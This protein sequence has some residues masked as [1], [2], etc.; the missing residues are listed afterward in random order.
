MICVKLRKENI[1]N[2]K[3]FQELYAQSQSSQHKEYLA[4]TSSLAPLESNGYFFTHAMDSAI[5]ADMFVEEFIAQ[6]KHYP[7]L[8]AFIKANVNL[9]EIVVSYAKLHDLGK[10][11]KKLQAMFKDNNK[12]DSLDSHSFGSAV[13]C[14]NILNHKPITQFELEKLE[15]LPAF[16]DI[17]SLHHLQLVDTY[18]TRMRNYEINLGSKE[19]NHYITK[20]TVK[21]LQTYFA[22][23][24]ENM[25]GQDK[26][27]PLVVRMLV[28]NLVKMA[29]DLASNKE[30]YTEQPFNSAKVYATY[31][32]K[33]KYEYG[34]TNMAHTYNLLYQ[35]LGN[36][37]ESILYYCKRNNIKDL[38]PKRKL[39]YAFVLSEAQSLINL[40][41]QQ[42]KDKQQYL[43][44][45]SKQAGT[46][47]I[48]QKYK[49]DLEQE[50][51]Q[52]KAQLP[53]PKKK[54]FF[55]F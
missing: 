38:I 46:I 49:Q 14:N 25:R 6:C 15:T 50:N 48:L 24:I 5:F 34:Y 10:L 21:Y 55:W 13:I 39:G 31:Y 44:T 30:R 45:I 22:R 12:T 41:Y 28:L 33:H 36:R 3:L 19:P 42:E 29:D 11:E 40:R 8:L 20:E 1:M 35:S 37:Q 9:E 43:A 23:D 4:K 53:K 27:I 2:E 7:D 47:Q 51:A 16:I 26:S 32:D 54:R 18:I 52:L 17:L